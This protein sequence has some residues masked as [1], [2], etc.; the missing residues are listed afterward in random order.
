MLYELI[1]KT[2]LILSSDH[3]AIF[4][5]ADLT[6]ELVAIALLLCF[7]TMSSLEF[8]FPKLAYTGWQSRQSYQ[9]NLSLFVFNSILITVFSVSTLLMIAERCSGYGLLSHVPSPALKALVSLLAIDLLLYLWH[10]ACHRMG[11][12]WV[13][14]RVHHSDPYL[15]VSTAFRLHFVEIFATTCLKALLIILLG[16]DKMLVLSIETLLTLCIMFHHTNTRFKYEQLLGYFIIVPL[17]HRVHH[18]K[19]R[20]EHDQNYG[21]VF[22]FWDRLFGT[23]LVVEPEKIGVKGNPPEDVF[24]LIKFGFG[25]Q[26]RICNGTPANVELMI[27]EAAFYKAEKRNFCPGYELRDWLDARADV[28][29]VANHQRKM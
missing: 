1:A 2:N 6:G 27:A 14:H 26:P 9:T 3:W 17:L 15:N 13:F 8:R 24:N 12:L 11:F 4:W 25:W 28:L 23:L 29:D 21:T 20:S 7:T 19:K 5:P 18:S 22:S 10:Q 16:I